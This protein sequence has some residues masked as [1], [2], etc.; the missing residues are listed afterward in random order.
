[1]TPRQIACCSLLVPL[2]VGWLLACSDA[3]TTPAPTGPSNTAGSSGSA[4]SGGMSQGSS[5]SAGAAGSTSAGGATGTAGAGVSGSAGTSS[6]GT[7]GSGGSGGSGGSAGSG[8]SGGMPDTTNPMDCLPAFQE[9]CGPEIDFQNL[10]PGNS[11]NFDAVITDVPTTMKWAACTS[12]SI[13]YRT[14]DEVP[15]THETIHFIVDNHDG[16]AYAT[17]SEIHLSTNHIKNYGD[18]DEAF[19]EFRGV[20]VHEVSHLYQENGGSS[21]GALIEGMA[22]FVRIRAGLYNPGRRG[23]GGNWDGAYTTSGF[24]FSWL[25]GP[26]EYHD[27]G[28]PQY[29]REIGYRINQLMPDGKA[30]IQEEIETTFGTDIDTLWTQYQDAI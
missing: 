17:G 8:G 28:H 23:Q 14:A 26:C 7:S 6:A 25:A 18:A 16:V 10:D 3:G 21:D 29:D 22:D 4:G 24:F 30:A 19:I 15:R 9:V 11:A 13:M 20:M 2:S 5:G 12:C 27:D 1:M